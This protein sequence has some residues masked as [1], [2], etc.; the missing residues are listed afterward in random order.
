MMLKVEKGKDQ[1]T[2]KVRPNRITPDF[3]MESL[4]ARRATKSETTGVSP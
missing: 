4:K 1:V 3:L 2:Y